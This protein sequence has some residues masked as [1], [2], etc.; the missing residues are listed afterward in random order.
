MNK[1]VLGTAQFGM[2]YGINNIRGKI[3]RP[4]VSKILA[5]AAMA[6]VDMIDTASGYGESEAVIGDFFRSCRTRFKVIS[7]LPR[8]SASEVR[9]FFSESLRSLGVPALYGY[10]VHDLESYK[11]DEKI[12]REMEGLKA[13]GIVEKIGFSLYSPADMEYLFARGLKIDIVQIPFSI[14]DQRFGPYLAKLKERGV[15]IHARSIFLQGLAFKKPEEL[16]PFFRKIKDKI[17]ALRSLSYTSGASI[18]SLCFGFITANGLIDKIVVGVDGVDNMTE[19][20][21]VRD[22][23]PLDKKTLMSVS[24]LA[25]DD[26][27]ILLPFNWK[28]TGRAA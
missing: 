10:L 19:I 9:R 21:E 2:D 17:T 6:G 22:A 25:V 14:F 23:A 16:D 27:N 5:K 26:D 7:K 15:E 11:T 4:D 28:L 8:S 24:D 3:P 18:P 12:W 13:E 1:I 20:I